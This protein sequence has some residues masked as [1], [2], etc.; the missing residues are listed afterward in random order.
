M[1]MT[2]IQLDGVE[3]ESLKIIFGRNLDTLMRKSGV[4]G[5]QLAADVGVSQSMVSKWINAKSIPDS[6][7]IDEMRK[8][9]NWSPAQLFGE[10]SDEPPP[11]DAAIALRSLAEALGFERPRLKRKPIQTG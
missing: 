3:L 2:L 7:V 1:I 11:I 8:R 5:I 9:Y 4:T 6:L 10:E